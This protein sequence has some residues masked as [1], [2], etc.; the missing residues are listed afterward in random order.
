MLSNWFSLAL[1][2]AEW[3]WAQAT[4]GLV[5]IGI[6]LLAVWTIIDGITRDRK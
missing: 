5:I 6:A 4:P 3:D 1:T 2:W